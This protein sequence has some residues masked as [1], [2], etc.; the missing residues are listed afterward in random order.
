MTLADEVNLLDSGWQFGSKLT[1]NHVW[2]AFIIV[3]L[4]DDCVRTNT[5][6]R[7]PHTGE[8]KDRFSVAMLDRNNRIILYGQPEVPHCCNK[9]THFYPNANGESKCQVIVCD[10]ISMGCPCCGIFR[11]VKPLQNNRHRFCATHFAYHKVC[12]ING[13]NQPTLTDKK[14][15]AD[16]LHQKMERMNFEHGR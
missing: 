12:A 4:L 11:C 1:S 10:G 9:W 2:D 14:A 7:V 15:C 13:C 6:L 8:Q 5:M 16:P 3:S